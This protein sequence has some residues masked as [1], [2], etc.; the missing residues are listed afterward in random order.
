M[1]R[2]VILGAMTVVIA[3]ASGFVSGYRYRSAEFDAN[4]AALIA[5]AEARA[6]ARA[7]A[8]GASIAEAE[9]TEAAAEDAA[10]RRDAGALARISAYRAS[11][12]TS[13]PLPPDEVAA[14]NAMIDEANQ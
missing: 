7:A 4:Q 12:P 2:G 3:I 13:E 11:A 5:A 10:K 8:I 9:A 1:I 14:M 6:E